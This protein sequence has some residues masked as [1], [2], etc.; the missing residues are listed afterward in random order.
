MPRLDSFLK[1]SSRLNPSDSNKSV[2]VLQVTKAAS[3][4][5]LEFAD[6]GL[7]YLSVVRFAPCTLAGDTHLELGS[8][9]SV[10]QRSLMRETENYPNATGFHDFR[11]VSSQGTASGLTDVAP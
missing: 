11:F 9:A 4:S 3:I 10:T 6:T 5:K 7:Q 2:P 8:W 1:G